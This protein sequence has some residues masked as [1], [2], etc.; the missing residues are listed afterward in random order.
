MEKCEERYSDFRAVKS[1]NKQ[2]LGRVS[3]LFAMDALQIRKGVEHEL[4][5]S[6]PISGAQ[7]F[8]G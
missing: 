2:Q 3:T 5:V 4:P 6:L 1:T 7:K 8:I